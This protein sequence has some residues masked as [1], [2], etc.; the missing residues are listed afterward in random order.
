MNDELRAITKNQ[1]NFDSAV[2]MSSLI[3]SEKYSCSRSPLILSNGSTAIAGR[4]GSANRRTRLFCF[5]RR[6]GLCIAWPVHGAD[7]ANPLARNGA[8]EPLFLAVVAD[9]VSSG[10]DPAVQRRVR[11]DPSAPHQ[12]NEIVPADDAIAVFQQVNQQVEYLRLHRNQFA[13]TAQLATIG[14][15]DVVIEVEFHVRYRIFLKKQSSPSHEEIKRQ[16][17]SWRHSPCILPKPGVAIPLPV[18]EPIS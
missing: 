5:Y 4:S 18:A 2:M 12:R 1:R 3:P 8:D 15:E 13:A 14:V 10:V 9:R 17:K 6:C 7:E 11:D 16:A